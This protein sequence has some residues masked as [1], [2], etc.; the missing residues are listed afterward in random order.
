M[1]DEVA[2]RGCF[3]SLYLPTRI[4]RCLNAGQDAVKPRLGATERTMPIIFESGFLI[5]DANAGAAGIRLTCMG[6]KSLRQRRKEGLT[7]ESRAAIAFKA[8]A[9]VGPPAPK[10]G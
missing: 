4:R 2:L 7:K 6:P 9:P 5:S 8:V 3:Q 1:M 10:I